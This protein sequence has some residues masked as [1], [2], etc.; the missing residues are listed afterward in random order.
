M[1]PK[2]QQPTIT[3]STRSVIPGEPVSEYYE[4]LRASQI[5]AGSLHAGTFDLER[6]DEL[7]GVQNEAYVRGLSRVAE[8]SS[9]NNDYIVP[10][11][12]KPEVPEDELN[13]R[14]ERAVDI[15]TRAPGQ[16]VVMRRYAIE[17]YTKRDVDLAA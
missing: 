10:G 11:Q 16:L 8:N 5:E 12:A 4:G 6:D 2:R 17:N 1:F 7:F 9:N 14:Y 15:V 13:E 3:A